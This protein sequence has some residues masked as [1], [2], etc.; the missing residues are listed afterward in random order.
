IDRRRE[1][2]SKLNEL[3]FRAVKEVLVLSETQLPQVYRD[4]IDD[5][6]NI[7]RRGQS[8]TVR[9]DIPE[10]TAIPIENPNHWLK[11]P[12]VICVFVD[13][14]GS[15]KLSVTAHE[16][17]TASAYQLFTGTAVRLFAEF[18]T[19]YIDVQG[20][21]VFGLFNSDQVYRALAAAVTFK[22]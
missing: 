11:I 21:G 9:N 1:R 5:Q 14:K 8:V 13:M 18:E 15:T 6:L 17:G 12:D 19:P 20:D 2:L 16:R 10:T 22:T 4:L 7:F 3:W